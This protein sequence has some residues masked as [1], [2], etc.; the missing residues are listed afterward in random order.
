V[1]AVGTLVGFMEQHRAVG[2]AGS[3]LRDLNGMAQTSA[4]RFHNI[5][6]ELESGLRLGM[7]SRILAK[8]RIAAPPREDAHR[9]D[10]VAGASMIVRREVLDKVGLL[11]EGYFM[12]YEEVDFC[13]RARAAGWETWYVPESRVVHLV[14]KSSGVTDRTQSGRALPRY[15]FDS[16]RRFFQK[17]HGRL[18]AVLAEGAY[19]LGYCVWRLRRVVQLKAGVA[20]PHRLRRGF[21][22]IVWPALCGRS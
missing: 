7:A 14:G 3:R 19:L 18:Y 22:W 10:W 6:G 13:M 21:H 20:E 9:A 8:W 17:N 4:F 12:Y 5:L 15:W 16:R 1:G 11:D 2:I